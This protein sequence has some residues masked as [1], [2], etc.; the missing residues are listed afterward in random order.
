MKILFAIVCVIRGQR[1]AQD[2][3]AD[4]RN[5]A[6]R[7]YFIRL[8]SQEIKLDEKEHECL[9][10]HICAGDSFDRFF[11][12]RPVSKAAAKGKSGKQGPRVSYSGKGRNSCSNKIRTR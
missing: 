11:R 10:G 5:S 2:A 8:S 12:L 6:N 4:A 9:Y 7:L 1:L 3:L